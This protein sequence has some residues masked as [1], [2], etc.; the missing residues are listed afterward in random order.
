M[1]PLA[2]VKS[3]ILDFSLDNQLQLLAFLTDNICSK[4]VAK[5]QKFTFRRK[6]GGY[7]GKIWMAPDF[8]E[9]P[10]CFTEYV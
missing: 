2:E 10:D 7:E 8:D 4:M 3:R 9:T 6:L 1:S 5:S